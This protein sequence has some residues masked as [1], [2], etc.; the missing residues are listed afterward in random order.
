MESVRYAL[1]GGLKSAIDPKPPIFNIRHFCCGAKPGKSGEF[2]AKR[3]WRDW[4]ANQAEA[5][6]FK[7]NENILSNVESV[8]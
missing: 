7:C 4:K 3:F 1:K 6:M 8:S 2:F 5:R